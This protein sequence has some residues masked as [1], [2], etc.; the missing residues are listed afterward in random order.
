MPARDHIIL[1]PGFGGF[2]SLGPLHYYSGATACLRASSAAAPDGELTVHVFGDL[3]TASVDA[4]ADKLRR[5]LAAQT[6]AGVIR[7]GS[8]GD[9]DRVH[10]VGHSTG[11]LDLRAFLLDL[12]RRIESKGTVRLGRR[13]C[14]EGCGRQT[15]PSPPSQHPGETSLWRRQFASI[16]LRRISYQGRVSSAKSMPSWA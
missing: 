12:E 11:G 9:G 6:D 4:R 15:C 8:A 10:L 13:R 5:W 2:D 1:V 14:V 7:R 3:P 16:S